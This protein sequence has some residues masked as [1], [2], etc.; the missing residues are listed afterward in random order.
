M[1]KLINWTKDHKKGFFGLIAMTTSIFI[2]YFFEFYESIGLLFIQF[3]LG[4][5]LTG[6]KTLA[7]A[8]LKMGGKK[9]LVYS[10]IGMLLK[11]HALDVSSKFF[12]EHSVSRYKDN[13]VILMKM[14]I[15]DIKR[16]PLV[17][18][19]KVSL[20]TF[21]SIPIV[22]LFW[23]KFLGATIQKIIYAFIYPLFTLLMSM[24]TVGLQFFA[25]AGA[26]V[27]ELLMIGVFIEII[28]GFTFGKKILSYVDKGIVFVFGLIIWIEKK[29]NRYGVSPKQH[30]INVSKKINSYIENIIDKNIS[31][32]DKLERNNMR[33]VNIVEELSQRRHDR[34][35]ASTK[36]YNKPEP[37]HIKMM[38]IAK[39]KKLP[40][41]LK[42]DRKKYTTT[43]NRMDK[44]RKL[45]I[46]SRNN[47][48]RTYLHM[49]FNGLSHIEVSFH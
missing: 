7:G 27:F 46:E 41:N 25:S 8:I 23:T 48:K 5:K 37:L 16:A 47:R 13:L 6:V 1:N 29:L 3:G 26:F 2:V 32:I 40:Y 45:K 15:E 24:L 11:R 10:T 28:K 49:P 20:T 19:I 17:Q 43:G 39:R 44:N 22:Y 14:K 30:L 42:K 12:V 34:A 38:R 9:A 18:K 4:I 35:L 36:S 33:Y 21:F 31:F